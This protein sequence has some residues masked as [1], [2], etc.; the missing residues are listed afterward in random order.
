MLH[1]IKN[2]VY[3]S[4]LLFLSLRSQ[5]GS[6]SPQILL[7]FSPGRSTGKGCERLVL[8]EVFREWCDMFRYS[9]EEKKI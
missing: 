9:F 1:F 8:K 3:S 7:H 6:L 5:S 4:E 2:F